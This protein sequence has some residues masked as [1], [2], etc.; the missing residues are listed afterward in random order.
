MNFCF[1]YDDVLQFECLDRAEI[2]QQRFNPFDRQ[3]NVPIAA[4]DGD[5][6]PS[7]WNRFTKYEHDLVKSQN[8]TNESPFCQLCSIFRSTVD[9]IDQPL[10]NDAHED[11]NSVIETH[12]HG[13]DLVGVLITPHSSSSNNILNSS[14]SGS[15]KKCQPRTATSNGEAD[16]DDDDECV[17]AVE[18]SNT[19]FAPISTS[20]PQF[21][22][23]TVGPSEFASGTIHQRIAVAAIPNV[24][25]AQ[26]SMPRAVS[27]SSPSVY[28]TPQSQQRRNSNTSGN[29]SD[30]DGN[31]RIGN[32]KRAA[33]T[34]S[35]YFV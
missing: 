6:E 31:A 21:N 29:S 34:S 28:Q 23:P 2:T 9:D 33:A 27:S 30:G 7:F 18:P 19:I 35:D 14:L 13:N 22:Q 17:D 8:T 24:N 15:F 4:T 16:N 11:E 25:F 26:S 1:V 10:P 20:Q 32:Y 12:T 5:A 3:V